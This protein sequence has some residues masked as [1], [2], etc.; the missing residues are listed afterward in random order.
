MNKGDQPHLVFNIDNVL[1]AN[2][3]KHLG[4]V[5]DKSMLQNRKLCRKNISKFKM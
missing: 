2:S 5:F 4:V 3:Q 1:K